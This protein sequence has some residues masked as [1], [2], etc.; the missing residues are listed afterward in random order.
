MS[1]P[2]APRRAVFVAVLAAVVGLLFVVRGRELFR[3]PLL[4]QADLA[5][6]AL[7]IANAKHGAEL[8]G[9]YSRFEFHHPGPAFFYVYAAAERWLH[10]AWR[11]VPSPGN[12]HLIAAVVLQAAF[13]AAAVAWLAALIG[14]AAWL[15]G[16]LLALALY[17]VG[18]S[19]AFTSIWPPHVLAVPFLCFL[20]AATAVATGRVRAAVPL[21]LAGGFLVHGHVA[22]PLFVGVIGGW[23]LVA[24]ARQWRRENPADTVAALIRADRWTLAICAGLLALFLLPLVVEVVSHGARSNVAAILARSEANARGHAS[25]GQ[26]VVFLLSY[27]VT[28]RSADR[29]LTAFGPGIGAF[30]RAHVVGVAFWTGV[31]ALPLV[32][33]LTWARRWATEERRVFSAGAIALGLA[34]AGALVW[35]MAQADGVRHYNGFFFDGL[36]GFA[37]LLDVALLVR[38]LNLRAERWVRIGAFATAALVA[39]WAWRVRPIAAE[40]RGHSI[41][42]GVAAALATE[43]DRRPKLLVFDDEAWPVAAAVAVEL[44]RRDVEVRVDPWWAFMFHR[45][46]DRGTRPPE[47]FDVWRIGPEKG[48]DAV[49]LVWNWTLTRAPAALEPAGAAITFGGDGGAFRYVVAGVEVGEPTRDGFVNDRRV[50]LRFAP[51]AANADVRLVFEATRVDA[52]RGAM[53]AEVLFNGAPLGRVVL[54]D[55]GRAEARVPAAAWNAARVASLE[56]RFPEAF[57]ERRALRPDYEAWRSWR[58]RA[59]RTAA[60]GNR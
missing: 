53:P 27:P 52:A 49:P 13:L 33:A 18:H 34:I 59:V 24:G 30:L 17:S 21:F 46:H 32:A 19:E 57:A 47:E 10:D 29:L 5:L 56:L 28:D 41:R 11:L 6:N 15:P 22:Q 8:L 16:A 54:D 3:Q 12:A 39:V 23:A 20:V 60:E 9:N 51:A 45:Q 31:L 36:F 48:A 4:E 37:L 42:A 1:S 35:G 40:E 7:Q 58:L 26:A 50:V 55:A 25:F 38:A 14:R 44:V 43:T 2:A